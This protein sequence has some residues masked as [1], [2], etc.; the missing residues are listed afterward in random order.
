MKRKFKLRRGIVGKIYEK[1][2]FKREAKE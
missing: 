2:G 1:M